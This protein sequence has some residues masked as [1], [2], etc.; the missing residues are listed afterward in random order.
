M[1]I[2]LFKL[3]NLSGLTEELTKRG[4]KKSSDVDAGDSKFTLYHL[5]KEEGKLGWSNVFV[6]FNV[7]YISN[8][9]PPKGIVV[10]QTDFGN[11]AIGYGYTSFILQKYADDE[12]PFD[13]AKRIDISNISRVATES[14]RNIGSKTTTRTLRK[15][16]ELNVDAG[17]VTK[18]LSIIPQDIELYGSKIDVG[19]SLKFNEN[20]SLTEEFIEFIRNIN[21]VIET[22]KPKR[23]IPTL[24]VEDD[25]EEIE[26]LN[27]EVFNLIE[28][29]SHDIDLIDLEVDGTSLMYAQDNEFKI[30]YDRSS[31]NTPTLNFNNLNEII[32][33]NN[34]RR[35]EFYQKAKL[36]Y[37]NDD[38]ETKYSKPLYD[39]LRVEMKEEK[40]FLYEGKWYKYNDDYFKLIQEKVLRIS[41]NVS[42]NPEFDGIDDKSKDIIIDSKVK[43]REVRVNKYL[44][45]TIS[46]SISLD[47]VFFIGRY[48][49]TVNKNTYSVEIADLIIKNGKAEYL[50]LKLSDYFGKELSCCFDQS[51]VATEVITTNGKEVFEKLG[52]DQDEFEI[53]IVSCWFFVKNLPTNRIGVI[54]LNSINSII[55]KRNLCEWY[56]LILTKGLTPKI[57]INTI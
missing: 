57:R 9:K 35:F 21:E 33:E 18:A 12:F 15:I 45:N 30:R 46:N 52:L 2:N 1:A 49:D 42:H 31:F 11:Y 34:F 51:I 43:Y 19:K 56:D 32:N 39:Y 41:G 50:S 26:R 24:I 55:F 25:E 47:R 22:E 20:I 13:F 44:T 17:A 48:E 28:E 53:G 36:Q 5:D 14:L 10:I 16:T 37:L 23:E 4:F 6:I 29:D 8:Y 7:E 54:D 40:T 38:G 3:R 27:S